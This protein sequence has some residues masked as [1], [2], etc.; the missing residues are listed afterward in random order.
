MAVPSA[1][2]VV[3]AAVVEAA[4]DEAAVTGVVVEV[5]TGVATFG[6]PA[7]VPGPGFNVSGLGALDAVSGADVSGDGVSGDDVE[8][9]R[10]PSDRVESV[11]GN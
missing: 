11:P 3:E 6:A 2:A 7:L 8:T 10:A 4:A 5:G 9:A 1:A